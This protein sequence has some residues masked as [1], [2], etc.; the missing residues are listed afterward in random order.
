MDSTDLI[1][2]SISKKLNNGDFFIKVT[3]ALD[4]SIKGLTDITMKQN[5]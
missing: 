3:N 1:D 4:E 2:L 5:F